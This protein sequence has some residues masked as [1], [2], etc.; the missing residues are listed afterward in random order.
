M[1][2]ETAVRQVVNLCFLARFL[3]DSLRI[4]DSNIRGAAKSA[5]AERIEPIAG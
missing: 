4:L 3:P 1:R 5:R 2:A